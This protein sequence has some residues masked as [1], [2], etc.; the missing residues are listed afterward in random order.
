MVKHVVM[1]DFKDAEG[2]TA[3]E[4]AQI[5]KD[6]GLALMGKVPT[7]RSME[8]ALNELESVKSHD[9]VLIATFDSFEG[10]KEYDEHPEH[11]KVVKHIRATFTERH[12]VD[13][14][15]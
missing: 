10:L 7:L 11:Q 8:I 13:Y 1:F 12:A 4:N 3:L 2:R 14:T 15:F 6:M 9:L 5:A